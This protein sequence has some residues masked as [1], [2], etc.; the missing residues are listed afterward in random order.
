MK[1]CLLCFYPTYEALKH[2]SQGFN[3]FKIFFRFYPT[4]EALKPCWCC[5]AVVCSYPFLPYLWGIETIKFPDEEDWRLWVYSLPMRDWNLVMTG[6]PSNISGVYSL[7]MR[8]WND[9]R[10]RVGHPPA[11]LFIAY[12][13]GIET[14]ML[15]FKLFLGWK[16]F[17]LPMRHWNS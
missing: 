3:K 4:Y 6:R 11:P 9:A 8:D 10:G 5:K 7:P 13:W 15:I 16:V 2:F 14:L 12:L 1:E 17:T